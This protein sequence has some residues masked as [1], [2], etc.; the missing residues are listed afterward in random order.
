M[1]LKFHQSAMVLDSQ[2]DPIWSSGSW[3]TLDETKHEKWLNP[4]WPMHILSVKNVM[5]AFWHMIYQLFL[6]SNYLTMSHRFIISHAYI[7]T[8]NEKRLTA[9]C[10]LYYIDLIF[11]RIKNTKFSK[12]YLTNMS[13]AP[14][15]YPSTLAT[16]HLLNRKRERKKR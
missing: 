4:F 2:L 5:E 13:C 16:N 9:S 15:M 8:H 3:C 11:S 12:N 7:S 1:K 10:L 6:H 14:T